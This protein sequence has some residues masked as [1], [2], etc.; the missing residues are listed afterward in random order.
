MVLPVGHGHIPDTNL[1]LVDVIHLE[2]DPLFPVD[3]HGDQR[4]PD[5]GKKGTELLAGQ[6]D[7]TASPDSVLSGVL[8]YNQTGQ[9][10]C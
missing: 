10:Q 8:L 5:E 9:R 1:S 3:K 4:S 2:I 6:A 7:D